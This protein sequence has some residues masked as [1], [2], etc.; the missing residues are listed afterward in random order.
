MKNFLVAIV[1]L[2][3]ASLG[4]GTDFV[5]TNQRTNLI[6]T[7]GEEAT[8]SVSVLRDGKALKEG[9]IDATLD[10]FGPSV[11]LKRKVNLADENPFM[12]KGCLLEPGF[13]RLTL[14]G[15]NASK[16][17]SVGYEPEKIR[18]GSPSPDDFDSFWADA[19]RKIAEEIPLDLRLERIDEKSTDDFD[20]FRLS[21]A[22]YSRRVYGLMTVPKKEGRYPVDFAINAAGFG[23]W[24]NDLRGRADAVCV[25]MSVYPFEMD[26]DW[27]KHDLQALAY[28]PFQSRMM[29]TY[30]TKCWQAGIASARETYFYYPVILAIDRVVEWLAQAPYVEARNFRYQG[31]SQGGG[32]GIM[33]VA[34]NHRFAR[35]VFYVPAL[36]DTLGCLKGRQS[37]WPSIT[38]SYS[39]PEEKASVF[40]NAPYFDAA[41]FMSRITCPVRVVVGFA[42]TTCPPC[43]VYSAYNELTVEDK[44]IYHGIGMGHSCFGRFYEELGSWANR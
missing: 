36:T 3:A 17:W 24:T 39:S 15:E 13:L 2:V 18:K 5:I 16:V 8:F 30:G 44:A 6:Y 21:V 14:K 23:D 29:E 28:E 25:K 40:R 10:N 34:L 27:K 35:A 4:A 12:V 26:W 1:I 22:T 7:V 9:S 38:E 33:L 41:N 11:Q 31:T 32:L 20:F 42:D 19:R 43:A 37:G